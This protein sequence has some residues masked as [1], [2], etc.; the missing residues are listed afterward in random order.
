MNASTPLV[1]PVMQDPATNLALW[2]AA[3]RFQNQ[4]IGLR[5]G[6][7]A[8]TL[9]AMAGPVEGGTWHVTRDGLALRLERCDFGA[10][11]GAALDGPVTMETLSALPGDLAEALSLA[12]VE[13]L[14]EALA[15]AGPVTAGPCPDPMPP[16]RLLITV[17]RGGAE[18]ASLLACGSAA[19]M[20]QLLRG[21][22]PLPGLPPAEIAALVPCFWQ[23]LGG[24]LR[25]RRAALEGLVP[26][27]AL[28]NGPVANACRVQVGGHEVRASRE[29]TGWRIEA[30]M[31]DD[32]LDPQP[33]LPEV[34]G[35]GDIPVR[36]DFRIAHGQM[37]LDALGQLAV[38]GLLPMQVEPPAPG[39]AVDILANGSKIGE[40]RLILVDDRPAVRIA[41]LFGM[42]GH[43]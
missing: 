37:T 12:A 19:A 4:P 6:V 30:A 10:L 11:A 35:P 9:V 24:G 29:D 17:Q 41:R 15:L 36:I 40:G 2:N 38:G 20:A 3:M 26:G 42:G 32:S 21:F 23:A 31:S 43:D 22:G 25:I 27:D 34:Q 16:Q 18:I 33:D 28:L 5:D 7:L 14:T 1:D 13:I 39:D 8:V